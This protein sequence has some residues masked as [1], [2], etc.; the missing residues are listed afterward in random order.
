M[1][2]NAQASD[3]YLRTLTPTGAADQGRLTSVAG[4][5]SSAATA[6]TA[7]FQ[8]LVTLIEAFLDHEEWRARAEGSGRR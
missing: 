6:R 4:P 1:G 2:S 7:L 3:D 8:L 5:T